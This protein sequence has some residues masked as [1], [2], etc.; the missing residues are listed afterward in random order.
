MGGKDLL[1]ALVADP[2]ERC[3]RVDEIREEHEKRDNAPEIDL[4]PVENAL[5]KLHEAGEAYER[6]LEKLSTMSSGVVPAKV[7]SRARPTLIDPFSAMEIFCAGNSST[8]RTRRW[9]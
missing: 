2:L 6:A 9:T 1:G 3:R 5:A 7:L 8:V 4:A